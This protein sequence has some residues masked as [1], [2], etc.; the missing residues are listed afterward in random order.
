MEKGKIAPSAV[1]QGCRTL[2]LLRPLWLKNLFNRAVQPI[3][4]A[5]VR[6]L[7]GFLLYLRPGWP[8]ER[9]MEHLG[10]KRF[11]RRRFIFRS[12]GIWS[13]PHAPSAMNC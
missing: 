9:P 7:E 2:R 13:F 11:V 8:K 10:A 12:N 5:C 3:F 4:L 6:Y 1:P